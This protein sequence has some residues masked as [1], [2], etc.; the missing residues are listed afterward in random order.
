MVRSF[1]LVLA[2]ALVAAPACS[3][4]KEKDDAPAGKAADPAAATS[5]AD[6]PAPAAA[7]PCDAAPAALVSEVLGLPGFA[8]KNAETQ[9]TVTICQYQRSGSPRSFTLRIESGSSAA[10]AYDHSKADVKDYKVE[11]IPGLG[12]KAYRYTMGGLGNDVG[13]NVVVLKGEHLLQ[14]SMLGGDPAKLA[15]L[16]RR[17]AASL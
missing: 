12:D 9:G 13:N 11:D 10:A 14:A 3:K 16:S 4:K 5:A 8:T 7:S 1:A 6:T 2:A 15:E 17:I